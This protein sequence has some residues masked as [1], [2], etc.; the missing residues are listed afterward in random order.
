MDKTLLPFKENEVA[1]IRLRKG[2]ETIQVKR[3]EKDSS[4]WNIL[5]PVAGPA[6][7]GTV[8]S[9]LFDLRDGR[10]KQFFKESNLEQFGLK[11]PSRELTLV[12]KDGKTESI[13]L[14]NSN[15]DHSLYLLCLP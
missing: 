3:D 13:R 15:G 1:E 10:V 4:L 14:G 9:L 5:S 7:T 11:V 8:N 6:D 2:T 12:L